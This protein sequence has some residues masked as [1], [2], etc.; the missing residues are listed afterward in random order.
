MK[1]IVEVQNIKHQ[2][3]FCSDKY[4]ALKNCQALIVATEWNEFK[5]ADLKKV[6]KFLKK[7]NIID[8]RNIYN[9]DKIKEIGF[10]YLSIG[11]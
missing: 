2:I 11:R 1:N 7:P 3:N 5:N 4:S 8:G 6:K 9:L 10:N